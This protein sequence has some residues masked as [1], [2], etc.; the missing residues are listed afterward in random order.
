VKADDSSLEPGEYKTVHEAAV[1]LLNKG[2]AWGRLPTPVDDLMEAARLKVARRSVFDLQAMAEYAMKVGK[3]TAA[4]VKS[5][6]EKVLGIYDVQENVVHIDET[7]NQ[8]KQTFLKL[9]ETGH[10]EIPHQSGLFK[11]IQDCAKHLAPET[12]ELFE[13]EANTFASIVL[14][15]DNTFAAMTADY[16]FSIKVPLKYGRK[17]GA[18]VYASIREYVRRSHRACAVIVLMPTEVCAVKGLNATVRRVQLSTDF[19][20]RF[21]SLV[22]PAE[23]TYSHDLM[24]A[25]PMGSRKMSSP[26]GLTLDDQNGVPHEFVAEGFKTPYNTFIL[27]HC[28]ATLTTSFIIPSL[29]AA[30]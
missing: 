17:F 13:R 30:Q 24:A 28:T 22:L 3:Q 25:V 29:T 26:V 12:A 10:K 19:F 1:N 18:S 11:F 4:T 23:L 7:V 8:E 16:E 6:I 2:G 5:A 20:K 9:H 15:Q 14:F 27:L 21:G